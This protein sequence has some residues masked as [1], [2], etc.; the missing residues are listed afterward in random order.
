MLVQRFHPYIHSS[1][2]P[3]VVKRSVYWTVRPS[4]S[5]TVFRLMV[6]QLDRSSVRLLDRFSSNGPSIGP[7]VYWT[8]FRLTVP[9]LDRSSVHPS[10]AACSLNRF[11]VSPFVRSSV[12]FT[13]SSYALSYLT[14]IRSLYF[15]SFVPCSS[16]I[17][18]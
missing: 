8:V 1:I 3:F 16:K 11:S 4:V 9:L 7:F 18:R 10:A 2:G 12:R 15:P 6:H 14:K 13:S 5:R 17:S